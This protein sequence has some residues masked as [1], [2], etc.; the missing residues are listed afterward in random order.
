MTRVARHDLLY[1]L[2]RYLHPNLR[3]VKNQIIFC[4]STARSRFTMGSMMKPMYFGLHVS[5]RVGPAH[6][7]RPRLGYMDPSRLV[8]SRSNVDDGRRGVTGGPL[9]SVLNADGTS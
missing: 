9:S 2:F 3:L 4:P 8:T 1:C 6:P 5:L 7:S